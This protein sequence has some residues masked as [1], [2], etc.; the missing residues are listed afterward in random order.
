MIKYKKKKQSLK[1]GII[2][3]EI[4]EDITLVKIL[5][6]CYEKGTLT[7]QQWEKIFSKC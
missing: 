3:T 1:I 4:W 7:I 5:S 2:C 6:G